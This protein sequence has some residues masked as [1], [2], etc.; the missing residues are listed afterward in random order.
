MATTTQSNVASL[1]LLLFIAFT[2]MVIWWEYFNT[3]QP[4]VGAAMFSIFFLLFVTFVGFGDWLGILGF[5]KK[6]FMTMA[7]V[8]GTYS[9][10]V[11]HDSDMMT[12]YFYAY[13]RYAKSSNFEDYSERGWVQRFLTR[14]AP[15][16]VMYITDKKSMFEFVDGFLGD[17]PEGAVV[18]HGS[19]RDNIRG[20]S[21]VSYQ[22]RWR[23]K[24]LEAMNTIS[25]LHTIAE[26]AHSISEQLTQSNSKDLVNAGLQIGSLADN[27]FKA[28][29][30]IHGGKDDRKQ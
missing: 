22:D 2:G 27:I 25:E 21:Q 1:V 19:F 9:H 26:T 4:K 30:N 18:Y 7:G 12:V 17:T 5:K 6:N 16:R 15:V 3:P 29:S 10:H 8:V 20:V 23:F 24:Y 13:T 11:V 28:A 14:L